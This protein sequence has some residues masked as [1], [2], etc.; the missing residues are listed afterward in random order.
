[1]KTIR[2]RRF[3]LGGLAA[4][5]FP[6]IVKAAPP[7]S[8]LRPRARTAEFARVAGGG[9]DAL[10]A[11]FGLSGDVVCAVAD[12]ETGLELEAAN[13]TTGLPP[14]SV[15]KALTALYALETLGTDYRFQTRL[16]AAGP[17]SN[18]ILDGDLILAGGGDPILTTDDLA[19][20]ASALKSAGI[21]EVRGAF[22]VYEAALPFVNTIDPGQ[23]DHV[24]YSPAVSGIALNFNRVHFEWR[25][26]GKSYRVAMDARTERYRPEVAMAQ[27]KVV[28]R[29]LPVYTYEDAG[30]VDQWTVARGALGGGGARWLPV[31]RPGLYAGDVFRTMARAQGIVLPAARISGDLTQGTKVLATHESA[32]LVMIV[33]AMLKYST[34]LTAEMVGMSASVAR[35]DRPDSLRSSA[36]T[37]SR[38]AAERFGMTG[39]LLVD[40]SGLG[41]ASRMTPQDLVAALVN[42]RKD[43]ILRPLLKPFVL[44]DAEGRANKAHPITVNAKTGTLNFVS[45]LGGYMTATDGT[46]LAFAIFAADTEA[47]SRIPRADR[48]RPRGA[49]SWNRRAKTLQQQ[50]IERW[51]ALYGT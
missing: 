27:M 33:K 13:G 46:E 1:M 24:G 31:R 36:A 7:V 29:N 10:I 28:S 17:V 42:A 20:L 11:R 45:G 6:A 5:A 37:M 35:G 19:T 18:G 8:S 26:S 22:K 40:H 30:S 38:W 34:N 9:I 51:G 47:R 14:A 39:T 48:E 12:V 25:A 50:L 23:P 15:A 41:D 49:R 2:S 32:R 44:R 43:D 16:L 4:V 3:V 21:R